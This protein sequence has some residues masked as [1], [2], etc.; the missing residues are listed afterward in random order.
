MPSWEFIKDITKD[1]NVDAIVKAIIAMAKK[2]RIKVIAEGVETE[3]QLKFL[4]LHDCDQLQGFIYS[5]PVPDYEFVN[6]LASEKILDLDFS[7]SF[8]FNI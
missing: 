5:R 1:T 7:T 4:R 6:L 3:E 8:N 2:L